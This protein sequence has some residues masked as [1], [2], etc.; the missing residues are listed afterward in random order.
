MVLRVDPDIDIRYVSGEHWL[1]LLALTKAPPRREGERKPKDRILRVAHDGRLV[2]LWHSRLGRLPCDAQ[3][4][5]LELSELSKL[6][7]NARII[8]L[9]PD[10][11]Q[12]LA[13]R[14]QSVAE[15][16]EDLVLHLMKILEA[17]E[18]TPDVRIYPDRS[19]PKL[20]RSLR[21]GALD[22]ILPEGRT[23]VALVT[24]DG[25][26]YT[27]LILRRG[28]RGIDLLTT[29]E[30]FTHAE[31][32]R[33]ARITPAWIAELSDRIG[34]RYG[35][36][37]LAIGCEHRDFWNLRRDPS[38]LNVERSVRAGGLV[39]HAFPLRVRLAIWGLQSRFET[40]LAR[41]PRDAARRKTAP[42]T[43][44]EYALV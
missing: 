10:G 24:K 32:P 43:D 39:L 8:A 17:F 31:M 14:W 36:P 7:D 44:A 42:L 9:T 22:L 34:A 3:H 20:P 6:Y 23:V 13:E 30:V 4:A 33:P 16:E 26:L 15:P 19:A 40:K 35:K 25:E 21:M 38:S 11:L 28:P 27:S 29:D 41:M 18:A 12:Q 5:D 1:N 2:K 37:F